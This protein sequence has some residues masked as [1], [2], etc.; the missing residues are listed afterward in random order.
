MMAD[1]VIPLNAWKG[2]ID[3]TARG[4]KKNLRNLML[5]MQNV[6]GLGRSVCYNEFAGRVEWRGQPLQD[7][8]TVDIR[9]M[10]ED[11]GYEPQTTDV[12][13]ALVRHA[14]DNAYDPVRDY[15]D[16][17]VWDKVP[18][19]NRWLQTYMGAPDHEILEIFGAKFLIGAVARVYDPG[20]QMDNMLVFEGKQGA[21]KT[22]AV[23]ALFGREY[24]ISSISDF[25]SK[26]AS[27]ALQGRWVAEIAELAAL[28][29]TDITDVKKFITETVD[30]FR[31]VHGK[32][33][34]DRPRRCVFI[35]TT[36]EH[37]YLKDSTGNR[38]FWPV[39]CG[40]V[41]VAELSAARDQL[42]AEAVVRYRAQEAWWITDAEM[43]TKAEGIQGD[44]AESD[45]WGDAI[46]RW[47]DKPENAALEILTVGGVLTEA[48]KM[49][50][51]RQGRADEMRVA[52]HLTKRKWS[53]VK[54]RLFKG[55]PPIWCWA[56]PE[57]KA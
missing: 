12:L 55:S 25:K 56:K 48:I 50:L 33:T 40:D 17:I 3:T 57:L 27:I 1:K 9:L 47:L 8:D 16:G 6:P 49:P 2:K 26:E 29:K 23:A 41:M 5:H 22:T 30:Q 4:P 45:T 43:L 14:H 24:M 36:N 7:E 35:G 34:I 20:C 28:K 37:Q 31:P 51:D 15:L 21:G 46:D 13:P 52:A 38:R 11:A 44:R 18:R 53:R 39:P 32:N 10:I 19:I 42:W 54:R